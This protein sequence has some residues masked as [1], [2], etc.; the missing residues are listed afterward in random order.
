[1]EKIVPFLPP[2]YIRNSFVQT[3]L[4]SLMR[5][6]WPEHPMDRSAKGVVLDAG[7]GVRLLGQYS[8]S[9]ENKGLLILIH[10]WEGSADSNYIQRTARRYFE[11]GFSIF[12]LNLRDHGNTHHLNPEPFNGSLLRE[13]YEAVRKAAQTFGKHVPV[14]LS[15][16]SM[17]GNFT[18]RIAKEH[19]KGKKPIPNL[20]YCMAVSPAMHPKSATEMMDS[21]FLIGKYFLRKWKESLTKKSVHFPDLH[22]YPEILQGKS[23]M[24]IT[25]RIVSTTDHFQDIDHYFGSYTLSASDFKNL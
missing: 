3:M 4:A 5:Q 20:K 14:Y 12:R 7:K 19:S 22:P 21:K 13:T 24:D 17:G 2:F 8:F 1:M 25:D 6:N 23:V 18:I 11:K 15:G 9:H 16:F 10:G